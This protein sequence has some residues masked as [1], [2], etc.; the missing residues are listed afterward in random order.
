MYLG[1]KLNFMQIMMAKIHD[2]IKRIDVITGADLDLV[3]M[4]QKPGQIF[5]IA[6]QVMMMFIISNLEQVSC[7]RM[8]GMEFEK[9]IAFFIFSIICHHFRIHRVS[10]G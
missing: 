10:P 6:F 9:V 2:Q 7:N 1:S 4:F 3:D 8:L 5:K